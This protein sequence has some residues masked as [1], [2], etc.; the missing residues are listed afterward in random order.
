NPVAN[1]AKRDAELA[2][3]RENMLKIAIGML[4]F[5]FREGALPSH[6]GARYD[7][8]LPDGTPFIPP[9]WHGKPVLSWRVAILPYIGEEALAKEFN[10]TE[11]W[12]SE[13]NKKLIPRM[14]KLYA[15]PGGSPK[16]GETHYKVFVGTGA[17]FEPK[18]RTPT[19]RIAD[20]SSNTILVVESGEP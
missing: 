10:W 4:E 13:H 2:Q 6:D 11:P 17:L 3:G 19:H 5:E 14:P 16:P 7:S 8:P 15:T 1:A 9:P 18:K 20:G 12:D